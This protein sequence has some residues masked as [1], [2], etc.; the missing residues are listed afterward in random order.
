MS[1]QAGLGG[2]EVEREARVAG[3]RGKLQMAC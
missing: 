2:E 1:T 3:N